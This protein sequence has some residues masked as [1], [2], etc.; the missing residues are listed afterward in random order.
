MLWGGGTLDVLTFQHYTSSDVNVENKYICSQSFNSVWAKIFRKQYLLDNRI[1]FD[2]NL[3]IAEDLKFV[4]DC[5][6]NTDRIKF[7]PEAYYVYIRNSTSAMANVS[8]NKIC[9]TLDVCKYEINKLSSSQNA[10][11][12]KKAIS[13]NLLSI[14]IRTKKY[15]AEENKHLIA[16]L[17]KIKKYFC[18]INNF[19]KNI[20]ILIIKLFGIEF[21][22][23]VFC[24]K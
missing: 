4:F 1:T 8:Y 17:K 15:S 10:K 3:I 9:N 24:K 16:E 5:Y 19:K 13:E 14:L 21:F 11:L 12:C 23:K 22:V 2:E 6:N 18:F 7:N 20:C